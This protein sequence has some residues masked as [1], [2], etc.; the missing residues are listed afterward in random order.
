MESGSREYNYNYNYS[1]SSSFSHNDDTG[2][3]GNDN[4]D[5]NDEIAAFILDGKRL[6]MGQQICC[7]GGGAVYRAEYA[8]KEVAV[9]KV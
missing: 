2:G 1:Y 5:D 8:G 3:D 7:G 6:K 9:K 4:D